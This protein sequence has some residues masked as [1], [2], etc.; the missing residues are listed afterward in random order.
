MTPIRDIG[1]TCAPEYLE[2]YPTLP[3]SHRKVISALQNCRSGHDGHSLYQGHNCG[4]HPRVKHSW[5][6]RHCPQ[7]QPHTTQ[8]WLPHH[9]DNQLPGPHCLVPFTV[10]APLRPFSRSHQRLAYQ[11]MFTASSHA[12]K[13]LAHEE[14]FIGPNLPGFPGI[15]HPWGRQLQDHP[16]IHSMVPGGGLSADR[17][18]WRP[19]RASV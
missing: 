18:T 11:A 9:L 3:T 2:R 16:H 4:K 12:R 8:Q 14:R 13:R 7:G 1:N 5:G 10:P 19:S 6:N 15:L 17:T